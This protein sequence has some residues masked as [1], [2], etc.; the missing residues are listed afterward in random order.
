MVEQNAF[1]PLGARVPQRHGALFPLG[2]VGVGQAP[3]GVPKSRAFFVAQIHFAAVR[4]VV[5]RAVL[6][7][8]VE[9]DGCFQ[10]AADV[11]IWTNPPMAGFGCGCVLIFIRSLRRLAIYNVLCRLPKVH[12]WRTTT[13]TSQG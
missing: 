5:E 3:A 4:V 12:L 6:A 13:S 2:G 9:E 7:A 10:L 8:D 1:G 11:P